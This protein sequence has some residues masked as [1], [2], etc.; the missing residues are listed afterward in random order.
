MRPFIASGVGERRWIAGV[1]RRL[2]VKKGR[3]WRCPPTL[4]GD[5]PA[6]DFI[7][8]QCRRMP[9]GEVQPPTR[10][11][12]LGNDLRPESDVR[13]PND[14]SP[15]DKGN[16]VL[17]I[18]QRRCVVDIALNEAPGTASSTANARAAAIAAVEKSS[19]VTIAPRRARRIESSPKWQCR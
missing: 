9:F 8:R 2:V 11:Q 15:G 4:Q 1:R 6:V 13:K 19:P 3:R 12:K 17:G 10:R 16:V 18:E 5:Q 14:R 7:E